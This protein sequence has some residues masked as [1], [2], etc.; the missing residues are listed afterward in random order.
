MRGR[1]RRIESGCST[2]S[3][4]LFICDWLKRVLSLWTRRIQP[5]DVLL[6]DRDHFQITLFQPALQGRARGERRDLDAR[7]VVLRT[8]RRELVLERLLTIA[9]MIELK[10]QVNVDQSRQRQET[11]DHNPARQRSGV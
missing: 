1:P 3:A 5:H 7:D 4:G 8:K 2:S 9:E 6:G 10:R 11:G